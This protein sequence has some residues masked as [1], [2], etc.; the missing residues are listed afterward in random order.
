MKRRTALYASALLVGFLVVMLTRPRTTDLA[1][2]AQY[3]VA[4]ALNEVSK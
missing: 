3:G 1:D 2:L 4:Q